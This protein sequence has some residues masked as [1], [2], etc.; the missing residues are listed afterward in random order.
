MSN[1]RIAHARELYEKF[2]G[3]D[4]S[5]FNLAQAYCDA[6]DFA[7]ALEHLQA[8]AG[9]KRDWMVVQ[10]L[11]GKTL[12]ALDR[13]AEAK[14]VFERALQLAIAQHHDGPREELQELL[15]TL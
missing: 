4:L 1:D 7:G 13:S 12:I 5:R 10:I 8:L 14:P 6:G 15:A 2:F 9:K 3:N 11:L